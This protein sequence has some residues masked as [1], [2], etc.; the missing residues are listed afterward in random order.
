MRI[1]YS[2]RIRGVALLA[3]LFFGILCM[4]L[5]V[6]FILQLPVDVGATNILERNTK[7]FY[8]ADAGIQDTLAWMSRELGEG[9]EPC[10]LSDPNPSRSGALGSWTWNCQIEPD[11]GTPP[12]SLS[13]MRI[14]TLTSVASLDSKPRYRIVTQVQGGQSFAR[15]SLYTD[16]GDD[17]QYD[18]AVTSHL[19]IRGPVH[20]NRPIRFYTG[21]NFLSG[22]KPSERPFDSLVTTSAPINEW[23]GAGEPPASKLDY[24]F[25]NGAADIQYGTP[26]RPL[27]EDSSLLANAA[28][29]T[30]L[31]T[32]PPPG[33][34]IN[35]LGGV[36]IEGTVDSMEMK[37]NSN[38]H[39]VLEI[40]QGG[41]LTTIIEDSDN[42]VRI[43]TEPDGTS[44]AVAGIGSGVI[45]STGD[46]KSLKGVNKGP[47]TIA[48][49]FEDGRSIEI[50]GSLTRADTPL[51]VPLPLGNT[52]VPEPTGTRDR[53][54]LVSNDLYIANESV[55]PR[56]LNNPLF[57]Y[58]TILAA[59]RLQVRNQ[60]SGSPGAMVIYG[61]LSSGRTL[62]DS[63]IDPTGRTLSGYGGRTGWGTPEIHYDKLLANDPPP[64]YPSTAGTE[65]T[66]RSWVEQPL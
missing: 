38:D 23:G 9:R 13:G 45:Y 66:I 24:I 34:S 6:G 55:L 17:T 22:G 57:I 28:W 42:D 7:A 52:P 50:S 20:K 16:L 4:G 12:H 41:E 44:R 35:P 33:I 49:K 43:V 64:D 54:G 5:A 56:S 62:R 18:F 51:G 53:L 11:D 48:T 15:F 59:E 61:G 60:D 25:E 29:G 8:V 65:L 63:V 40:V 19:R 27:P 46:I 21:A 26:E 10:T 39:F 1:R 58:A 36:Y 2:L 32:I 3:A 31:P 47:H 30:T 37:V 14:Y